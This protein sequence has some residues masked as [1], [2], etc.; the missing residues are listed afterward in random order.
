MLLRQYALPLMTLACLATQ[1]WTPTVADERA[2][3]EPG[4]ESLFDGRTL[5]GW[6]GDL[7]MFRVEDG[8]I[9]AGSLYDV[10]PRNEF[11]CSK[12]QYG[13]FELRLEA[14]LRGDGTNA[15]VQ[16]RSQRVP[17][18]HEVSG[19]Q[20]DI[21]TMQDKPIW[22]WLYD[23]SRRNKFV[24]EG[25]AEMLRRVVKPGRWNDLVIRCTGPR[26]EIWVNG[27]RTVDHT[28]ADPEIA[29]RGVLGLQIHGGPPAEAAY[30][31]IRIKRLSADDESRAADARPIAPEKL[32][33]VKA[34][35]DDVQLVFA[36]DVMLDDLPGKVIARGEDPFREFADVVRG[37][38]AAIANLE[39][40]VATGGV[41]VKKPWAFRV[42]VRSPRA[43]TSFS[44]RVARQQSHGR[45]RSLRIT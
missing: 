30:R 16:F 25:D 34:T 22:G 37:A 41:E 33:E 43:Q 4:F 31:N 40:V 3:D 9:I 38:D 18:H 26:V 11:L 42:A 24:A 19:Y 17:N 29:R 27:Q 8:A 2:A 1:A 44:H 7:K 36:G 5:D 32:A 14:Q 12:R 35:A 28:E 20:C 21:G 15:G 23:E 45:L 13:D 39:C 10:I 6:E